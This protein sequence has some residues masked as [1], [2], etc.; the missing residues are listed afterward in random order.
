MPI[1]R[2][3][4]NSKS[5]VL[6][7][8]TRTPVAR[9][10][11]GLLYVSGP[12]LAMAYLGNAELTQEK[13]VANPFSDEPG[14]ER[15]YNTGDLVIEDED[16]LLHFCGRA[17]LQVQVKLVPFLVNQFD[18]W[19]VLDQVRGFRVEIEAIEACLLTHPNVGS[20]AIV[21]VT[22]QQTTSL[23]A[24]IV[25][26]SN[27]PLLYVDDFVAHCQKSLAHY[28]IPARFFKIEVMP[29]NQ[30]EKIDRR[31]LA[32]LPREEYTS[33]DTL[34][35]NNAEGFVDMTLAELWCE[36]LD[37]IS[38]PQLHARSHFLR[39]GGHSLT[40]ITLSAKIASTCG[41]SLT[42]V[43]LLRHPELGMMSKLVAEKKV[44]LCVRGSHPKIEAATIVPELYPLTLPQER[45]FSVQQNSPDSPFFNDGLAINIRGRV[46]EQ[47]LVEAVKEILGRHSVLRARLVQLDH[48]AVEQRIVKPDEAFFSRVFIAESLDRPRAEQQAHRIFAQPLD[49]FSGSLIKVALLTSHPEEHI[50]VVC[51]HH[52]IW[53]G[54]SDNVS[55]S[56][57][58][59]CH[60]YR[61]TTFRYS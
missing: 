17:D 31:T 34:E 2:A 6:D 53:D 20:V 57:L 18:S 49:L 15:M 45:L 12:G 8:E 9:G 7:R 51:A 46:D 32:K 13:F 30:S 4:E 44:E 27:S 14:Y 43:E 39:L 29:L 16:G 40:L 3:L 1:G 50:L 48:G 47:R 21:D 35:Q 28:E 56:A 24:Y 22:E 36:C 38:V 41:V 42:A 33:R 60:T 5:Y 55:F 54:F 26:S 11:E 58:T 25:Q 19:L 10:S 23:N 61:H 37:S 59:G 52:I